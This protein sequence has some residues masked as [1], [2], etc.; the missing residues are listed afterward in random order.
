MAGQCEHVSCGTKEKVW[1]PHY[2]QGRECGLKPHPY[3]TEC[4]LVK[5]LSSEKPRSIGFYVNI[6]TSLKE[7]YRMAKAQIRL[8]A[9]DMKNYDIDDNYGMDRHQQEELFIKIVQKYANVPDWVL[10]RFF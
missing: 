9:L 6:I 5:N 8:M 1:M 10:R 2:Y 7:D 4:G 3:C